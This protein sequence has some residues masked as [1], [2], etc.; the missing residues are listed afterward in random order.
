MPTPLF[1]LSSPRSGSTLLQ[2]VLN[3]YDD[4]LICGEH[5][6]FLKNM[7]TAWFRLLDDKSI[8]GYVFPLNAKNP[9]VSRDDL[10][11]RTDPAQWQAWLNFFSREEARQH[12]R[13]LVESFFRHPMMGEEHVWGFKEVR[14]GGRADR[15]IEFLADLFPEAIFVFLSRSV[16]DNIASQIKAFRNFSR[17]KATLP[18]RGFRDMCHRWCDLNGS[19]LEW[20][21]SGRLR[22]FWVRFE[23]LSE[24]LE[25]LGPLAEA[26]GKSIG[27][28]QRAV[29]DMEEG[30]GGVFGDATVHQRWKTISFPQLVAARLIAGELNDRL[31]HPSPPRAAIIP[32]RR[33][34]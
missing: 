22:S 20:H 28:D 32:R 13:Q 15:T 25:G 3:T 6:G 18:M 9:A 10:R 31:G 34:A 27:P 16:Y 7:A 8:G 23:D 17:L 12:F 19:L 4:V 2:R 30:R 24:G 29:L 21:N 26:L 33:A 11:K 5:G 1:I 14:Y